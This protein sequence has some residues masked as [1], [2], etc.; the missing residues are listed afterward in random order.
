M[1]EVID[2]FS[3]ESFCAVSASA[4]PLYEDRI[5]AVVVSDI[6]TVGG[7]SSAEADVKTAQMLALIFKSQL[8]QS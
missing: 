2:F 5:E 4:A 1:G 6:R 8:G 3:G 7:V